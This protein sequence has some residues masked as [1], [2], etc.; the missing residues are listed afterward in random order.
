MSSLLAILTDATCGANCW[1]AEEEIC[2]CSCNGKNHGVMLTSDGT[3]PERTC[4]IDGLMYRL[5]AVGSY[6]FINSLG[7]KALKSLGWKRID[8]KITYGD[9]SVYHFAH[10][11]H[12]SGSAIRVKTA[13]QNQK[14]WPEVKL[15]PEVKNPYMLW[16]AVDLPDAL[17]CEGPCHRCDE[18]RIDLWVEKNEGQKQTKGDWGFG[19]E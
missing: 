3:Q 10:Y 11:A 18:K 15:Y 6:T 19:P 1:Y 7:N 8:P 14:E 13:A 2:R 17:W 16:V 4:K 5:E 9:G 12:D